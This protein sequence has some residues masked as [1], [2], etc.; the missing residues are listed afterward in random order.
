MGGP[1][2]GRPYTTLHINHAYVVLLSSHFQRFCRDLHTEAIFHLWK[3]DTSPRRDILKFNLQLHRQLDSRNP[4]P[5]AIG[6]DF[7]RFDLS[8]WDL[9]KQNAPA[10][11]ARRQAL[12]EDLNRWRNAIAHQDF[13]SHG[14]H[15]AGP[16]LRL[17]RQ[18]RAACNALASRFD[19]VL[20]H[21]LATMTGVSPW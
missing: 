14:L 21:H 3:H 17:I 10:L 5:S 8:F 9:V 20:R 7:N 1:G 11:G 12:L 19:F 18:W 6:A 4:S 13:S 16:L 15:P 2:P